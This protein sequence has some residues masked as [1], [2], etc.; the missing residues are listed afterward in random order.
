MCGTYQVL[1]PKTQNADAIG[2]QETE[3]GDVAAL[4]DGGKKQTQRTGRL[5]LFRVEGDSM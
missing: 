2:V 5:Y 3:H 4:E 1:E